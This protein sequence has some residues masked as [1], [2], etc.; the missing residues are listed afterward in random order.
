MYLQ[1]WSENVL[2][3]QGLPA[4][5]AIV[6][7]ESGWLHQV[8]GFIRNA[9]HGLSWP[10]ASPVREANTPASYS[11]QCS[12]WESTTDAVLG[13]GGSDL[14]AIHGGCR[15][16]GGKKKRK[17]KSIGRRGSHLTNTQKK[18][19]QVLEA[20]TWRIWLLCVFDL[21]CRKVYVARE[22]LWLINTLTS[23]APN[24]LPSNYVHL[25]ILP[26]P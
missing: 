19:F 25:C 11:W 13:T 3:P 1:E 7:Q 24:I 18:A 20:Y 4:I 5:I 6:I 21:A 22:I 16:G 17:R 8:R 2:E 15:F 23:L 26:G 14:G 10:V 9:S 12:G